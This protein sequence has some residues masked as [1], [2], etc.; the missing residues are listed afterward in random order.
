M[1]SDSARVFEEAVWAAG[2]DFEADLKVRG[3]A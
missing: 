3:D 1:F 2:L